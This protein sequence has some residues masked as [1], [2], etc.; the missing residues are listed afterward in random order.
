MYSWS[1][2]LPPCEAPRRKCP[3]GALTNIYNLVIGKGDIFSSSR[4]N[5]VAGDLFFM[6]HIQVQKKYR[7]PIK[8]PE[9]LPTTPNSVALY[10]I[11]PVSLKL[12][13]IR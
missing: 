1:A 12:Y 2:C 13:A 7:P 4:L 9:R 3:W 10:K 5:A 11:G 8:T 6:S